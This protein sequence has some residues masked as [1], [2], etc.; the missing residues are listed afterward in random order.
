MNSKFKTQ[1]SKLRECA[2]KN[3]IILSFFI[4][5]FSLFAFAC[6]IPNLEKPECGAAQQVVKE[7]YSFHFGN[8]MK[9]TS[10]NL[11]LREKFLSHE[12][13]GN[14]SKQNESAADYFTQT[15]DYPKAFRIG[16]CEIIEPEKR[17][18]FAVVLFW[19]TDE[20]SEQR[21]VGVEVVKDNGR[22]LVNRVGD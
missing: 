4:F 9:F 10:E 20:R 2:S 22:W 17:V 3:L 21:E 6:S 14:L 1:S 12:L 15:S 13:F 7:L 18:N 19:K 5:Y 11:K 16:K 8:D